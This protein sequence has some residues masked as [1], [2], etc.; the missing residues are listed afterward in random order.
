MEFI[1]SRATE[2]LNIISNQSSEAIK[3]LKFIKTNRVS[4]P[5]KHVLV[6]IFEQFPNLETLVLEADI[7]YLRKSDF[8]NAKSLRNLYVGC[9]LT[10]ID[11]D[12]LKHA[13]RLWT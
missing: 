8:I 11:K 6:E 5:M 12:V 2:P 3:T 7:E 13:K 1:Q 9:K 10:K 4:F